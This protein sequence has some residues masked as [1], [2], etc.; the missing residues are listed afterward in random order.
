MI[1][2]I[3]TEGLTRR[4]GSLTAVEGLSLAVHTWVA[5]W[6]RSFV[7]A[8]AFGISMATAGMIIINADW[9][10]FYPWTLPALSLNSLQRGEPFVT[11]LLI[12]TVGSIIIVLVGGILFTQRD[13]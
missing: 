11:G 1:N 5:L 9:G 3:Q 6:W 7:V 12:S 8:M 10:R 2:V 4:F 13:V